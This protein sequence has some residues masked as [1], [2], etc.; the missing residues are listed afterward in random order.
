MIGK[1]ELSRQL[2]NRLSAYTASREAMRGWQ[3]VAHAHMQRF[4]SMS[5]QEIAKEY[6]HQSGM[7]YAH[8]YLKKEY[9]QQSVEQHAQQCIKQVLEE[10]NLCLLRSSA[11]SFDL[12]FK[13]DAAWMIT[14]TVLEETALTLQALQRLSPL[15]AVV[16]YERDDTVKR[17]LK[18]ALSHTKSRRQRWKLQRQ[19]QV[20]ARQAEISTV[21]IVS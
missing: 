9:H 4:S 19:V 5:L 3:E 14:P 13:N 20:A 1:A 11:R 10:D 16:A 7:K 12:L 15:S 17:G 8:Q 18:L 2:G 21:S 6:Y